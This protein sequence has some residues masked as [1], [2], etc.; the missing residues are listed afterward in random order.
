MFHPLQP[1]LFF[2]GR[3]ILSF[4]QFFVAFQ[5]SVSFIRGSKYLFELQGVPTSLELSHKNNCEQSEN[6]FS[7]ICIFAPKN[8]FFRIFF[9]NS[10]MKM[11]SLKQLFSNL[12][13]KLLH[14]INCF[15]EAIFILELAKKCSKS[16]FLAQK[17]TFLK[18]RCL[19]R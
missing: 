3:N 7:K 12:L 10:K 17:Y 16:N 14:K 5:F 1:L 2:Y 19:L 4:S 6:C 13:N 15:K 18:I 9:A 11:A 8:C